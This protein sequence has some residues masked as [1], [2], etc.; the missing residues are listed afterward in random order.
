MKNRLILFTL[1]FCF[2]ISPVYA[3]SI[4]FEDAS[5]ERAIMPG[6]RQKTV[7]LNVF[8]Q[9]EKKLDL[10]ISVSATQNIQDNSI[11]AAQID[12]IVPCGVNGFLYLT[13]IQSGLR[14]NVPENGYVEVSVSANAVYTA[15]S[16]SF[17]KKAYVRM[18]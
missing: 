5:N 16:C 15:G 12:S 7:I 2:S 9:Q 4:Q 11:I 1:I 14:L 8:S 18:G 10:N 3:Q 6:S 17:S 13:G